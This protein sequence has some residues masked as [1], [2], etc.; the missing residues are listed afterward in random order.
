MNAI[1]FLQDHSL[2]FQEWKPTSRPQV[3]KRHQ[4]LVEQKLLMKGKEQ[5]EQVGLHLELTRSPKRE[6]VQ[7]IQV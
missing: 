6:I 3:I 2:E 1:F 5:P 7:Q 4:E